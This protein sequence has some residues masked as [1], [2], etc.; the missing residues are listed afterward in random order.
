MAT[1]K[2][3]K[4]IVLFFILA[5]LVAAEPV[6][7]VPHSQTITAGAFSCMVIPGNDSVSGEAELGILCQAGADA[8]DSEITVVLL[9]PNR[10]IN[11]VL[12]YGDGE[13]A[14]LIRITQLQP[15]IADGWTAAGDVGIV[16]G[17]L[18]L[19]R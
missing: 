7:D 14:V 3:M 13:N 1:I 10:K 4:T 11:R 5:I 9:P 12:T 8:T 15:G 16:S 6:W 19:H 2:A 18:P 17:P